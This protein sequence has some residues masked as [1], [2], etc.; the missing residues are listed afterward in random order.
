MAASQLFKYCRREHMEAMLSRGAA[1][2]GTLYGWRQS[3][4][5][6]EMT[7]DEAE[8]ILG[9]PSGNLIFWDPPE[10][11]SFQADAEVTVEAE[12][13]A[14][15]RH[16]RT[17]AWRSENV[18]T[19]STST[20]YS[21]GQHRAWLANEGYDACYRINSARLFFRALSRAMP[22]LRFLFHESVVYVPE[23][24]DN[25]E[26]HGRFHHARLKRGGAYESQMEDR[27]LWKPLEPG[28]PVEPFTIERSRAGVYCERYR[29][30]SP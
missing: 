2:I 25:I 16:F 24:W 18:Y 26:I 5:Y 21:E 8:G 9:N 6:G 3:A 23:K 15:L 14:Q 17:L 12:G 27:A 10:P 19:F 20:E 11:D 13:P 22:A 28:A 1:R 7:A 4:R 29:V 30:L